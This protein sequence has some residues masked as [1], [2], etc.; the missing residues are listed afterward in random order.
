MIDAEA[1]H[2]DMSDSGVNLFSNNRAIAIVAAVFVLSTLF[3]QHNTVVVRHTQSKALM[4][5]SIFGTINCTEIASSPVCEKNKG[6]AVC[7]MCTEKAGLNMALRNPFGDI[8]CE[9]VVKLPLCK[10]NPDYMICSSC[11]E[12]T[13]LARANINPF[14]AINCTEINALA[15]CSDASAAGICGM[16]AQQ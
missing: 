9:E 14:A 10:Q 8:D 1:G 2:V 3:V 7:A 6:I 13:E 12:T 15:M 11:N 5:P 16:C 4:K